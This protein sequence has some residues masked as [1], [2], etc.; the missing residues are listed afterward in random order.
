MLECI[1]WVGISRSF[2]D[3]RFRA[4]FPF[5]WWV[6]ELMVFGFGLASA[7]VAWNFSGL[8]E[9]T[10]WLTCGLLIWIILGSR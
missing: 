7:C 10:L 2:G 4:E 9:F 3:F 8:G 6:L 5:L 1:V